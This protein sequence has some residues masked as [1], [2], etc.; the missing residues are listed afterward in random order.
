MGT[1]LASGTSMWRHPKSLT[2]EALTIT[3]YQEQD[4]RDRKH[5]VILS[6]P[7]CDPPMML[8]G[9]DFIMKIL[10][11]ELFQSPCICMC[12]C[13]STC[14]GQCYVFIKPTS[15]SSWAPTFPSPPSIRATWNVSQW[16]V[17]RRDVCHL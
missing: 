6:T 14:Q 1:L 5:V 4:G 9:L 8:Y 15:C 7:L 16:N 3:E 13:I 11:K 2:S 10:R 17:S 12:V